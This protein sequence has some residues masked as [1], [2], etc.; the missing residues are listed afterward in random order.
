MERGLKYAVGYRNG[1][2]RPV[3]PANFEADPTAYG[4]SHP[5]KMVKSAP[6][7]PGCGVLEMHPN[8]YGFLRDPKTNY[9]RELTDPLCRGA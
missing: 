2:N 1:Y 9:T 6:L 7:E 8:G 5:R 4:R 3:R